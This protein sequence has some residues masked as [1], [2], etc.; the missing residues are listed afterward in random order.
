MVQSLA[1]ALFSRKPVIF[2]DDVLGGLDWGT[3]RLVWEKVFGPDGLLR[4]N[5]TTVVLATHAC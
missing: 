5:G 1:R 3:Q 4:R 2:V